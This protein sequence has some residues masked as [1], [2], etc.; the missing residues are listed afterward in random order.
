MAHRERERER[1]REM[2]TF[3][4]ETQIIIM[5]VFSE[6]LGGRWGV[7]ERSRGEPEGGREGK[8][9]VCKFIQ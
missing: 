2:L 4:V 5:Y 1:E 9:Q 6:V 3:Y 8:L 7:D